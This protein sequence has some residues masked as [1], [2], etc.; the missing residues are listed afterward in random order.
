LKL[1]YSPEFPRYSQTMARTSTGK[2][3]ATAKTTPATKNMAAKPKTKAKIGQPK[4][5]RPKKNC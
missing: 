1:L 3:T 4:I 5:G 2:S